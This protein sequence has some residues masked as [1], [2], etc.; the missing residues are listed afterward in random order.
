M[1][2][3]ETKRMMK[4][5]AP[6]T[7]GVEGIPYIQL[8]L[9]TRELR[10]GLE[11]FENHLREAQHEVSAELQR[12]RDELGPRAGFEAETELI[13][14][15]YAVSVSFP[16]T[17]RRSFFLSGYAVFEQYVA[18]EALFQGQLKGLFLK[19][20]DLRENGI[21]QSR[22]YLVKAVGFRFPDDDHAWGRIQKYKDLRHM[23]MHRGTRLRASDSK[24]EESFRD[25]PDIVVKAGEN[26]V[27]NPG[28]VEATLTDFETFGYRLRALLTAFA[29]PEPKAVEEEGEQPK[30][31][32]L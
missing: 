31:A 22:S 4:E 17:L 11:F 5:A 2:D 21:A 23:L 9:R 7:A 20:N 26:V 3:D 28:F 13:H 15:G 18:W 24:L 19:P 25:I 6:L 14:T 27:V 29:F 10:S 32:A 1:L 12:T 16:Q 30:P 8:R